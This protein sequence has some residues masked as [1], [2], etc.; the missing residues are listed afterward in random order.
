M[1]ALLF[2]QLRVDDAPTHEGQDRPVEMQ[3]GPPHPGEGFPDRR[4]AGLRR[5]NSDE[6]QELGRTTGKQL[7][8]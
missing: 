5:Q 7:E 2:T 1:G 8:E 4:A 3:R 6:I